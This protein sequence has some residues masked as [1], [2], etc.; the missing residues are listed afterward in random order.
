MNMTVPGMAGD[1]CIQA[2][3]Q[4]PVSGSPPATPAGSG[5]GGEGCHLGTGLYPSP[6]NGDGRMHTWKKTSNDFYFD[7]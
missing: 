4:A 6:G 3:A 1:P 7:F 2:S 5:M